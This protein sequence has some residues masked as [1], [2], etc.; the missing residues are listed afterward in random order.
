MPDLLG[1]TMWTQGWGSLVTV[2]IL[3][4]WEKGDLGPLFSSDSNQFLGKLA[5]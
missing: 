5:I 4:V 1:E 3:D 2:T